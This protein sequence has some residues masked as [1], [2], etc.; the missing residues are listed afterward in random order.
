MIITIDGTSSSGKS[1]MASL[2]AK[3]LGFA[4]LNT[5]S[6]YRAI[7]LCVLRAKIDENDTENIIKCA[8]NANV[9]VKFEKGTSVIMIDNKPEVEALRSPEVS[10]LVATT[11]K[12]HEVRVRVR[13]IQGDIG[14]TTPK[15]IVEGRDIGSVVFPNAEIKIFITASLDVRAKRRQLEYEMLGKKKTLS[16][17]KEELRLRDDADEHRKESPLIIPQGAIIF[18]TSNYNI[19]QALNKLTE[20]VQNKMQVAH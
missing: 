16:E 19:E 2:L 11:S 1:T 12:I 7:A 5:G 13:E 20:I 8:Q 6:I 14:K 3:R 17:V 10:S 4:H 15:L 9:S 18:D